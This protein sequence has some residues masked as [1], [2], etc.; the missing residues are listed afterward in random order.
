MKER[1]LALEGFNPAQ[2]EIDL[3][4]TGRSF[5]FKTGGARTPAL[6]CQRPTPPRS[7]RE[8]R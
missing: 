8:R 2:E 3:G 5:E 6:S 1:S 7:G 4:F